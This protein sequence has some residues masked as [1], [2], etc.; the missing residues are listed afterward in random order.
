[1]YKATYIILVYIIL[2]KEVTSTRLT[3]LFYFKI[4]ITL[5]NEKRRRRKRKRRE[6]GKGIF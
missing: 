2:K 3:A 4:S 5:R 1:M 6:R